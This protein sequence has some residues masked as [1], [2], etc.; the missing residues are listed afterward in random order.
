MGHDEALSLL[1][2]C[3]TVRVQVRGMDQRRERGKKGCAHLSPAET[4][5]RASVCIRLAQRVDGCL[6]AR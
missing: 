3:G 5:R 2:G 1:G 4:G 6:A